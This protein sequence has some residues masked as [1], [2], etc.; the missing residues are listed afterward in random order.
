MREQS[1]IYTLLV[2][3]SLDAIDWHI[4][5]GRP[6]LVQPTSQMIDGLREE[7]VLVTGAGG[8]IG[9]AL[10]LRLAGIAPKRLVLLE[11]SESALFA[12]QS[13]LAEAAPQQFPQCILGSVLDS[14]LVEEVFENHAPS[15]VFHAAAFK[16]VPLLEEH[17]LAAIE[18]NVFGT[19]AIVATAVA[20][21][22]RVVL[23][24]TDKT[25]EPASIMGATKRVAECIV[26]GAGGTVLRLGNVLASSSSVAELFAQQ[27][28]SG[29]PLTITDPA[30]RRYFLTIKEA[31]DLLIAASAEADRPVLLAPDLRS[32]Q[33]ITDLAQFM[34]RVLAPG[35]D[36]SIE[37][38]EPR[39]GDKELEKLWSPDETAIPAMAQGLLSVQSNLM[40]AAALD[41][42][43]DALLQA[44]HARDLP[45]AIG[46]LRS[47]VPDFT[48]SSALLALAQRS[49]SRVAP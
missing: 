5:L 15:I 14:N 25:V 44:V 46:C 27:I 18:N 3:P 43:L 48:P 4:F 7:R 32:P 16:H 49:A 11:S 30:A 2:I 17:P 13:A 47:L 35:R 34:A 26:F 29:G 45:A 24:S 42:G 37:F 40:T 21:G 10:A 31:V 28:A 22:A 33:Y 6:H 8:S 38:T 12:L 39:P 41:C 9:S 19:Q 1:P 20:H 23:L 36:V